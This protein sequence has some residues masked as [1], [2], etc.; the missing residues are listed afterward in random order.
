MLA[1]TSSQSSLAAA[2]LSL[3]LERW[4]ERR[5]NYPR[6]A[7]RAGLQGEVRL[8]FL[9]SRGGQASGVRVVQSSGAAILDR[10]ATDLLRDAGPLPWPEP[11]QAEAIEVEVPIRYTLNPLETPR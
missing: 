7:R 2:D 5:Q 10:A 4:L 8:R 9:L 1:P 6:A 11:L 3:E